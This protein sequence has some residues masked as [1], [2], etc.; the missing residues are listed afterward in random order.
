MDMDVGAVV[1]LRANAV[2]RKLL[3]FPLVPQVEVVSVLARV[4]SFAEAANVMLAN[5]MSKTR[6]FP[7]WNV[8]SVRA[9][10]TTW[11][12][13]RLKVGAYGTSDL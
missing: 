4:A 6:A 9:E 13:S 3:A 1:A 8:V 2:A 12:V 7:R 10:R 5:E 11:A